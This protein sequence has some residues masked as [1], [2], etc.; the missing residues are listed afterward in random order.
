[1]KVRTGDSSGRRELEVSSGETRHWMEF[2]ECLAYIMGLVLPFAQLK[3]GC[4]L[5]SSGIGSYGHSY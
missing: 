3:R 5:C 2:Y 4:M 1:M